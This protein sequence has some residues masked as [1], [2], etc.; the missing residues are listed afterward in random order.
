M[1]SFLCF[2]YRCLTF[3]FG[4]YVVCSSS[5]YWFWLPLWYL[6]TL[7][8]VTRSLVF[9]CVC[10][11]DRCLSFFFLSL[12]CL[13]IFDLQILIIPLISSNSCYMLSFTD[14]KNPPSTFDTESNPMA[15]IQDGKSNL[16]WILS[17]FAAKEQ[18]LTNYFYPVYV[19]T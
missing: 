7:V 12:C 2:A 1:F 13:F 19:L 8:R 16:T 5:I 10:F 18:N 6:Q 4:H 11:V 14:S 17:R 15:N 3:S 9:L